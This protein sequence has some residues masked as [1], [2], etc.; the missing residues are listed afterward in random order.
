MAERYAR[1]AAKARLFARA[2]V[3]AG[4][5]YWWERVAMQLDYLAEA[6]RARSETWRC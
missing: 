2:D 6:A 1:L 3:P 4:G 5:W